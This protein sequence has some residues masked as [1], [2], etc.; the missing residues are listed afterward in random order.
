MQWT[1]V[2]DKAAYAQICTDFA[3]QIPLF[4]QNW[5]LDAAAQNWIPQV[6]FADVKPIGLWPTTEKRKLGQRYRTLPAYTPF[7]GPWFLPNA[8]NTNKQNDAALAALLEAQPRTIYQLE[9]PFYAGISADIWKQN[10][11]ETR[12]SVTYRIAPDE[13]EKVYARFSRMTKNLIER[14]EKKTEVRFDVL[15]EEFEPVLAQFLVK[16]GLKA[17]NSVE[18]IKNILQAAEH[19]NQ[20]QLL[21]AYQNETL[22]AGLIVVHDH[23]TS[24]ALH[25]VTNPDFPKSNA[26][27]VL[28]WHAIQDAMLRRHIFDFEGG[29]MPGIGAFYASFGAEKTPYLRAIRYMHPLVGKF[30]QFAKKLSGANSRFS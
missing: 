21:C 13:P 9:H 19:K 6:I 5:W 3:E 17:P 15:F 12:D 23:Q 2:Q 28:L 7:G 10:G 18:N 11:F 16:K 25:I 29:N 24:F 20:G 22:V 14:A 26:I 8:T 27:R 1:L 4:L 30:V